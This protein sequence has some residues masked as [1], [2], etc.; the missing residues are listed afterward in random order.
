MIKSDEDNLRLVGSIESV[1]ELNARFY[2]R[3]P[4]PWVPLTYSYPS[5]PHLMTAL[6]HQDIGDWKYQMESARLK[7][8][9][10]GCGTNQAILA[11]LRF[12]KATV[13]GSDLSGESLRIC[14][15][16]AKRIHISNL[17]LRQ[18]SINQVMYKDQFDYVICTGVIHHNADPAS[19]LLKLATALGPG[20][21]M[22]LMVYNRFHWIIPSAFQQSIRI[23]SQSLGTTNFESELSMAKKIIR[24]LPKESMMFQLAS[25]HNETPESQFADTLL[26]PVLYGYTVE[27]LGE[28]AE[29]CNLELLLP[30]LNQF[31]A[32]GE[33]PLGI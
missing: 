13:V 12:P 9:V 25:A 29:K 19:T 32:V 7:I 10:A 18:E 16:T 23:L 5:D 21:L 20:G 11:A 6:L 26:Q 8:W 15:E 14:S 2:G 4:Y 31:D 30:C 1:D 24:E 33:K 3:F 22:E 17:E 28:L 27:S